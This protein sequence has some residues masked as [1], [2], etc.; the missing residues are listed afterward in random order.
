MTESRRGGV[1]RL[2][3]IVITAIVLWG[4][5]FP[6]VGTWPTT[7]RRIENTDRLGINPSAIYYT[8][9]FR[10]PADFPEVRFPLNP[11]AVDSKRPSGQ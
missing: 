1:W 7:V 9:L 6:W 2:A 3:A 5:L 4:W 10:S 11:N 8:D